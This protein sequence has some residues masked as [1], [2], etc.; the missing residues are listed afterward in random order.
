M[1]SYIT[2]INIL[3]NCLIAFDY[4]DKIFY[5]QNLVSFWLNSDR[6]IKLSET[7]RIEDNRILNSNLIIKGGKNGF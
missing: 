5:Y 2:A 1:N 7:L 6:N 4:V 3:N